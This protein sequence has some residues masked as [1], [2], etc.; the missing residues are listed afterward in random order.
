MVCADRRGVFGGREDG[1][2]GA[3]PR[4]PKGSL[5]HLLHCVI[6]SF[7]AR[8]EYRDQH[9]NIQGPFTD[10]QMWEWHSGSFFNENLPI[11]T[12]A[13]DAF[14]KLGKSEAGFRDR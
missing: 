10:A 1:S 2:E 4:V 6:I 14:F 11:R 13:D 12:T 9:D 5:I 3:T 8:W 7:A